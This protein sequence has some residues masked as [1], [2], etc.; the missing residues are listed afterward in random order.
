M[1][2]GASLSAQEFADRLDMTVEDVHE[3]SRLGIL[4]PD[5]DGTLKDW[6]LGVVR[7]TK[8]FQEGG[9]S[10]DAISRAIEAGHFSFAFVQYVFREGYRGF[11]DDDFEEICR[12]SGANMEFVQHVFSAAGLPTPQPGDR[13]RVEDAERIPN[14]SGALTFGSG[15]PALLLRG[16]RIMGE[17]THR[18][19]EAQPYLYHHLMEEPLLRSGMSERAMRD[20]ITQVSPA[21]GDTA[22]RALVWMYRRHEEHATIEHLLEHLYGLMEELGIQEME[23]DHPPAIT[24]LDL[25]GYT[26]LTEERGDEAAAQIVAS[27]AE[28]VRGTSAPHQGRPVKWLGDGVMFHFHDPE[29]AVSA[30]LEMVER[31]PAEGLPPAHVGIAAGP[32]IARDGDYFGRT[33]NLAS[34]IASYAGPGQVLVTEEVKGEHHPGHVDF[35]EVGDVLLKGLAKPIRL[36]RAIHVG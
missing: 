31:I 35:E 24:F 36:H 5:V 10:L 2:D 13:I 26:R 15:D 9:I 32:I 25:V 7:L 14:L 34:R 23:P 17:S 19:A 6:E 3:L 21:L 18:I 4:Q 28:I 16:V 29:G 11:T 22:E 20:L 8:A 12:K 30:S 1:T 33:V 27:L